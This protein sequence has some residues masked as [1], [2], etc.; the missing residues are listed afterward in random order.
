MDHLPFIIA[1]YGLVAVGTLGLIGASYA[2]M[3]K[4]EKRVGDLGR[5][6]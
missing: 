1:A 3:R 5:N 6:R 2:R 4:A